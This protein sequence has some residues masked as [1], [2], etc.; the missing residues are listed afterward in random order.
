MKVKSIVLSS[1]LLLSSQVFAENTT[2]SNPDEVDLGN[3]KTECIYTSG[4]DTYSYVTTGECKF[5][6]TFDTDDA[7]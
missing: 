6:K 2:V 4:R 5:S 1:L 3:R 7:E